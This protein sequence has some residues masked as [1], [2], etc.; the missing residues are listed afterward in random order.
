MK[1]V[2]NTAPADKTS[3]NILSAESRVD[4]KPVKAQ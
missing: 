2:C 4:G 3:L 1:L